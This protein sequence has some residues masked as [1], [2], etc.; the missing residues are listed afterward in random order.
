M[1]SQ[2]IHLQEMLNKLKTGPTRRSTMT[3]RMMIMSL[4]SMNSSKKRN[5]LRVWQMSRYYSSNRKV[6]LKSAFWSMNKR[7]LQLQNGNLERMV[8]TITAGGT[9]RVLKLTLRYQHK[10]STRS[11]PGSKFSPPT[12]EEATAFYWF[13]M[14]SVFR[15]TNTTRFWSVLDA[16]YHKR[17]NWGVNCSLWKR[18]SWMNKKCGKNTSRAKILSLIS[19]LQAKRSIWKLRN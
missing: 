15:I 5:K 13:F 18:Y 4:T 17:Q 10:I 2:V 1:T 9:V 6:K 7:K 14:G 11:A 8:P 12:E 3:R 19:H 16:K